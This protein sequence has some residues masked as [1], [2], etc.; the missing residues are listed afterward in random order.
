LSWPLNS[1]LLSDLCGHHGW[2]PLNDLAGGEFTSM[3][4]E[5]AAFHSA[6]TPAG[7]IEVG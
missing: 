4:A 3:A 1:Q 6:R 7:T 5:V 2:Q